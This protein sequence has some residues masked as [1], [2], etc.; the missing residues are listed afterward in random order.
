MRILEICLIASLAL[1]LSASDAGLS[2]FEPRY[3]DCFK[4]DDKFAHP[5]ERVAPAY[6]YPHLKRH[7]GVVG[8]VVV[9]VE[10][11]VDGTPS[12][13]SVLYDTD[14]PDLSFSSSVV[15]GL[16][17]ARW[18]SQKKSGVWFYYKVDFELLSR[19]DPVPAK[20][21]VVYD[22]P[23]SESGCDH[24][25]TGVKEPNQAPEQT[26]PSGRGSP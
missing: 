26:A 9:L 5:K 3:G 18:E 20:P 24:P 15:A 21:G 12:K 4:W 14:A 2:S 6:V 11:A 13:I 23:C 22:F 17:D 8:E 19:G 25:R 16:K 1:R 7:A 10:L